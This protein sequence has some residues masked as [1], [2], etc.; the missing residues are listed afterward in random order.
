[1]RPGECFQ[2]RWNRLTMK[3]KNR[4]TITIPADIDKTGYEHN[5]PIS[6]RLLELFRAIGIKSDDS[7]IFPSPKN[8]N[9]PR[10]SIKEAFDKALHQCGLYGKGVTP[11]ALRR[12]RITIWDAIDSNAARHAAG[13][14]PKDVHVKHYVKMSPERLFRLV[15]L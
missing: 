5:V 13:H 9:V 12:T 7:L 4:Y 14:V 1:M 10:K 6:M 11:Y 3:G 8:P 15:G 2:I